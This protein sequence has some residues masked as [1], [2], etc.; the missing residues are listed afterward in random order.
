MPFSTA[1]RARRSPRDQHLLIN[2]R[3]GRD[4]VRLPGETIHQRAPVLDAVA[5]DAQQIDMR[6]RTQQPI[7]QVLAESVVDGQRDHERSYSRSY[8]RDR[9]AGDDANHGLAPF[10]AEVAGGDEEFKAHGKAVSCQHSAFSQIE[11]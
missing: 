8:S 3:R 1:P 11:L 4:H 7:L 2:R 5:L 10:G 9:D 6:S